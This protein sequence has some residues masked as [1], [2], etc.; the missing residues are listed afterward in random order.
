ML[1]PLRVNVPDPV[2]VRAPVPLKTPLK[3]VLLLS[4]PVVRVLLPRVVL[5]A[6]ASEP[7]VSLLSRSRIA[8]LET[9]TADELPI[10]EPDPLSAVRVPALIVVV[11]V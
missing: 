9:V 3:V 6:P 2:L 11:P 4:P 8:P 5:P 10:A 1:A 7:I